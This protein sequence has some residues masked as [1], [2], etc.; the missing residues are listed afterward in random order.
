MGALA[1]VR[2]KQVASAHGIS[3]EVSAEEVAPTPP[4]PFGYKGSPTIFV[5]G[6]DLDPA[7]RDNFA[8]RYG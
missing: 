3:V 7:A 6:F 1:V 2:I 5:N 4:L 8:T